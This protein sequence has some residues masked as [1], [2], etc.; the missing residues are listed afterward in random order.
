[1]LLWVNLHPGFGAGFLILAVWWAAEK[2]QARRGG[3]RE[4]Q[5]VHQQWSK[6]FGL[7]GLVCV[8]VTFANPYGIRLHEHVVAYLLS[9]NTVTAHVA[10]WLSPDFHNPRLYW[11]EL[12]L[13]LG[14]AAG[15]WHGLRRRFA[16]CA[17]T[18]G[19]MHLALV[20]VRNV[21]IFAIV[22]TAPLAS[23]VEHILRE[24]GWEFRLHTA[25][26]SLMR[27]RIGTLLCYVAALL[28]IAAVSTRSLRLG[29]Q[30]S[31][32][33]DAF[34]H[35]P[36]GRLFT[37]DR[38]A[39]YL[40]FAEPNRLVFFDGRN[41]VY[42]PEFVEAYKTVMRAAAGWH[43]VLN[44]YSLTTVLVPTRSPIAAALRESP[45]WNL[46]YHDPTAAVFVRLRLE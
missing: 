8:A 27:S 16:W 26:A 9:P 43:E 10:E 12:L 24:Q 15:L 29:P 34:A 2:I 23:Q 19:W 14:A 33:V 35:V 3:S 45:D 31:L 4:E 36:A 39:D 1:M 40:I 22:C 7:T 38:W 37:T 41:D 42:G 20:S 44:R 32:P 21:P 5:V 6:W 18:L 28:L 46:S 17:L 30:S 13:P 11:F 25:E